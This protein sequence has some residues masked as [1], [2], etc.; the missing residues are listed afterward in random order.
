MVT[1]DLGQT[2][3]GHIMLDI[4]EAA[5]DEIIDI[6][7][8]EQVDKN[9]APILIALDSGSGCEEATADRYRCRAGPQRWEAFAYK[10]MR[11]ATLVFRNLTKPLVIKHVGLRQVHAA[12]EDVGAFECSDEQ[13][14]QI[15]RVG[16]ETLRNCMFDAYVDCPWREQAHGGEN[17]GAVSGECLCVW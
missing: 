3:T 4:A 10:G 13:L 17:A 6:I 8:T 5:G 15:W 12:V 1:L 7:Y 11:Y 2:R 14:N 9:G 16:R